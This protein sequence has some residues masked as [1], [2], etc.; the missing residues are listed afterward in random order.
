MI[1][2]SIKNAHI[3]FHHD[4]NVLWFIMN[5]KVNFERGIYMGTRKKCVSIFT[6]FKSVISEYMKLIRS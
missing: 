2:I 6:K 4:A 3:T 5:F 1:K